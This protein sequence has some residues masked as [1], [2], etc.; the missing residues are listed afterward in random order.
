MT[1]RVFVEDSEQTFRREYGIADDEGNRTV[2]A[3]MTFEA[4]TPE[5]MKSKAMAD[6]VWRAL[7][8]CAEEAETRNR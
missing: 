2:L 5:A 7:T 3:W 6:W 8:N 1:W 4:M